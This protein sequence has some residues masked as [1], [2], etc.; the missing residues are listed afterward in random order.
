MKGLTSFRFIL[1]SRASSQPLYQEPLSFS[2]LFISQPPVALLPLLPRAVRPGWIE[3]ILLPSSRPYT[4]LYTAM[5]AAYS[6][7]PTNVLFFILAHNQL[8]IQFHCNNNNTYGKPSPHNHVRR[9]SSS[10]TFFWLLNIQ[11]I[12]NF[13]APHP[14]IKQAWWI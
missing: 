10:S 1:I 8:Y 7:V 4:L 9:S 11:V 6:T 13:F 2:L 12:A 3:P 5:T 14:P